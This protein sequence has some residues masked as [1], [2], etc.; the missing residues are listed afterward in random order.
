MVCLFKDGCPRFEDIGAVEEIRIAEPAMLET[1]RAAFGQ[2]ANRR[3]K[4]SIDAGYW[5]ANIR[6]QWKTYQRH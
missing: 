1:I 6:D 5:V 4:L 3:R 2:I